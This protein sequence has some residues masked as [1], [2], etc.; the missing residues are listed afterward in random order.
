MYV[1]QLKHAT[2]FLLHKYITAIQFVFCTESI[3]IRLLL[4]LNQNCWELNQVGSVITFNNNLQKLAN[5][6][7]REQW[8]NQTNNCREDSLKDPELARFMKSLFVCLYVNQEARKAKKVKILSCLFY[9]WFKGGGVWQGINLA[10][11]YLL[12][13]NWNWFN[14]KSQFSDLGGRV[15]EL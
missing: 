7:K 15:E 2:Y 13:L 11:F 4:T 14:F 12:Q 10:S 3:W 1:F 8:W 6:C 5:K 9:S